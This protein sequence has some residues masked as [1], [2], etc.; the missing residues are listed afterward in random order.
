MNKLNNKGFTLVEI[1]AVIVIIAILGMISVPSVLS[2]INSG[3][4]NSYNIMVSDIVTSSIQLF[5]EIEYNNSSIKKYNLDTPTNEYVTITTN[6]N[7]KE[8]NINLQTLV[9][10]GLLNASN[11]DS[12]QSKRAIINPKDKKNIGECTITITKIVGTNGNTS[13]E[14][15]STNTNES[16][17]KTEEYKN[18]IE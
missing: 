7:K 17:P 10:N 1:I 9:S 14:I 15:K 6:S 18:A 3:K 13:Y 12:E 5:E 2:I 8:I 16:C 4:N 11:S